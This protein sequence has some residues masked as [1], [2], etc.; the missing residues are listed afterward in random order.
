[1]GKNVLG[2]AILGDKGKSSETIVLE[3]N[4]KLK[5]R[6]TVLEDKD[7]CLRAIVLDDKNKSLWRVFLEY[8][9]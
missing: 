8:K 6:T 7:K 1:M 3:N 2:T 5:L 4:D 9:I